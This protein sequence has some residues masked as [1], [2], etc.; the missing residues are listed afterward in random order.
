MLGG[1]STRGAFAR[2]LSQAGARAF[3]VA[4]EREA[5]YVGAYYTARAGYGLTL[6]RRFI[7]TDVDRTEAA[8]AP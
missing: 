4:F 8:P 5:C 2:V 1:M 7:R 6:E 3:S